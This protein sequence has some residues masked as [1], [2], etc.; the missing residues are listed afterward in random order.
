ME[1]WKTFAFFPTL[2]LSPL[3]FALVQFERKNFHISGL[4]LL[5][6]KKGG[7]K[8]Q[9][10]VVGCVM[11]LP[12]SRRRYIFF[13]ILLISWLSLTMKPEQQSK[14]CERVAGSTTTSGNFPHSQLEHTNDE[15]EFIIMS[16]NQIGITESKWKGSERERNFP[17][18]NSIFVVVDCLNRAIIEKVG[19]FAFFFYL[20][21]THRRRLLPSHKLYVTLHMVEAS[22]L[23]LAFHT[24]NSDIS[25]STLEIFHS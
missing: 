15:R 9:Q 24:P 23:L 17:S 19:C 13:T 21:L 12:Y 6:M 14:S 7:E 18:K 4:G 25:I 8:K 20:A 5:L 3:A 2:S 10:S 16:N 11:L 22:R 1:N